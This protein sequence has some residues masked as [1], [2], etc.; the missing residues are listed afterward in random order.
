MEIK[1][2]IDENVNLV[3][4][5]IQ[6][7]GEITCEQLKVL[8]LHNNSITQITNLDQL[9][10]LTHLYLQWNRIQKIENLNHLKH[11]RK[12][13]L[14]YNEISHLNG[15]DQLCY[16][17][18]LHLEYQNLSQQNEFTF[19]VTSLIGISVCIWFKNC[20][21]KYDFNSI[22]DI[23]VFQNSL[24]FLN[25]S[26]LKM[27]NLDLLKYL[28]NL[29]ELIAADNHF[30]SSEYIASSIRQHLNLKSASFV[31]CPAQKNDIYYRNKIIS[32]S[33]RLGL[34]SQS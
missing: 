34:F 24:H 11:L 20:S 2:L 19:D 18:E 13:Y 10:H 29:N 33:Q 23:Y 27:S 28:P 15:I 26:G 5:F 21:F 4:F 32:D 16:L 8:Y 9:I 14:S 30:E 1:T 7:Q 31:G 6:L 3:F 22:M 12:L 17:E 25:I